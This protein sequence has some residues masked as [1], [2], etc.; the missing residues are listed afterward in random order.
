MKA[1]AQATMRDL[2][3]RIGRK[4]GELDVKAAEHDAEAAGEYAVNALDFAWW[5]A[6]QA[7]LTVPAR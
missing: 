7:G 5:A 4:R 2:R 6:V 1:G 3:D